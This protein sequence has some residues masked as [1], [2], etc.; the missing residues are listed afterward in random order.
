MS[1]MNSNFEDTTKALQELAQFEI[2]GSNIVSQAI[3][4]IDNNEI[5]STLI[6]IKQECEENIRELESLIHEQGLEAPRHTKDFKG[7][8]MQG[9]TAIRGITGDQGVLNALHTN[10][11]MLIKAFEKALK[12]DLPSEIKSHLQKIYEIDKRHLNYV[13]SRI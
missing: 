2:D 11:Q 8:I 4:N 1:I 3:E 6:S 7:F 5:K 10:I 9:Y 13:A 12:A